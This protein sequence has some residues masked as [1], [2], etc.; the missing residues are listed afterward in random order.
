MGKKNRQRDEFWKQAKRVCRLNERQVAM[1]KQLGMNPKKLPS[2][3]PSSSQPWKAPVGVFIEE[4][5]AKRF[6]KEIRTR[7]GV[8][9]REN[10]EKPLRDRTPDRCVSQLENLVCYF[11]N[12]S[13]GLEGALASRRASPDLLNRLA[14]ALRR[15]AED[16]EAGHALPQIPEMDFGDDAEQEFSPG[17]DEMAGLDDEIPF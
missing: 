6:G 11:A 3:I 4:L 5:S 13:D 16:I 15:L 17:D 8:L 7:S 9:P 12:L 14:K 2:L 1:A 10:T